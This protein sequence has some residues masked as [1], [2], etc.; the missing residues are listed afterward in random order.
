M[1]LFMGIG[2][3]PRQALPQVVTP[4]RRATGWC[5]YEDFVSRKA[6]Y[7][8]MFRIRS[9]S[10]RGYVTKFEGFL[11]QIGHSLPGLIDNTECFRVDRTAVDVRRIIDS[12]KASYLLKN[13]QVV[14][15]TWSPP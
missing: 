3:G 4:F 10:D 9:D 13:I 6:Y 11:S 2:L 12:D 14:E 1:T 15:T 5:V 7:S 8:N